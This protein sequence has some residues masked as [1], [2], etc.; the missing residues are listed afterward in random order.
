MCW[1]LSCD[2]RVIEAGQWRR[3]TLNPE[4][5]PKLIFHYKTSVKGWWWIFPESNFQITY[6]WDLGNHLDMRL[7]GNKWL[8][9]LMYLPL[10]QFILKHY[11]HFLIANIR[12]G[13]MFPAK[14]SAWNLINVL[15]LLPTSII[16]V[17]QSWKPTRRLFTALNL[18]QKCFIKIRWTTLLLPAQCWI[19]SCPNR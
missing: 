11:P 5:Q 18:T 1:E 9:R 4:I 2:G 15:A 14:H 10:N 8:C 6:R 19:F 13:L 12:T 17:R 3:S 16:L 7:H